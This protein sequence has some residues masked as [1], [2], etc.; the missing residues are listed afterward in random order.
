MPVAEEKAC[1][2]GPVGL[3]NPRLD[4]ADGVKV[5]TSPLRAPRS[6]RSALKGGGVRQG[7]GE[8]GTFRPPE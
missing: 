5:E 7:C 8:T 4:R 6:P 1:S 2:A 3:T